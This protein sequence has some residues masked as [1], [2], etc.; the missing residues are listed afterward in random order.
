MCVRKK[1]KAFPDDSQQGLMET[2]RSRRKFLI[3]YLF[4]LIP[5]TQEAA[6]ESNRDTETHIRVTSHSSHAIPLTVEV[7]RTTPT[8]KPPA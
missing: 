1:Y 5:E 7:A 3:I 8:P 2:K 6:A 4:Y